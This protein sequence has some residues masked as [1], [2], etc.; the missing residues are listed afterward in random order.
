[1]NPFIDSALDPVLDK[2]AQA[3][4]EAQAGI[5]AQA[6][7]AG[8]FGGSRE[9]VSKMLSDRNYRDSVAQ[10]SGQML[11]QGWQQAV[12]QATGNVANEQQSNMLNAQLGPTLICLMPV[13]RTSLRGRPLALNSQAGI[14]NAQMGTNVNLANAAAQNAMQ[15]Q[16]QNL[17]FQG[18]QADAGRFLDAVRLQQALDAQGAQ[19]GMGIAQGLA[20]LGGQQQA[21]TQNAL[22]WYWKELGNLSNLLKIGNPGNTVNTTG[23]QTTNENST[24]NTTSEKP[25]DWA[26][27]GLGGLGLAGKFFGF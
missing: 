22:D 9:A 26:S 3:N 10:T 8:A 24:A 5:G 16:Y 15:N 12:A 1:M 13:P 17:S 21:T 6:A 11:G 18:A 14:A 23:T 20:G 2:M 27:M 7:A 19:T 25:V 4:A